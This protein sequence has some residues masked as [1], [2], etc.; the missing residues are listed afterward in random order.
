MHH[1]PLDLALSVCK[2]PDTSI[3]GHEQKQTDEPYIIHWV[4]DPILEGMI[5]VPH[6]M[7][8]NL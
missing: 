2:R 8:T 5:L 4:F 6:E 1:N 7:I 3:T